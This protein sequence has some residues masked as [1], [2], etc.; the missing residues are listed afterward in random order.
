VLSIVIP[1]YRKP[2]L[3]QRTLGA[4]EPQVDEVTVGCEIVVVDDGS[5]DST[6]EV[7]E[8]MAGRLP[9]VVVRPPGNEGRAK[10]R[11]R[12]W[13]AATGTGVLFLDDDI[14]LAPGS[15]AAHAAA[16][17]REPAGYLGDVVT[18]AEVVDSTLFDYLDTRGVA[19][20]R[21]DAPAPAR[22]FLT[23]NASVPRA[24]LEAVGGFDERFGAYGFEDMEI[25]F[26]MEDGPGLGFFHLPAAR[27]QHI[28]HHTLEEY[29]EKKEIC[30]RETLPLLARLHPRRMAEM[31]LDVLPGM[32][33]EVGCE[34][35][36]L[37]WLL[38]LSFASGAPWAIRT[39]VRAWPGSLAPGARRR[40]YDYLVMSAYAK[41]LRQPVMS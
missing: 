8:T 14:V 4:L 7:L 18:A 9:L 2:D 17:E 34:N 3:L 27:G 13:R 23:Q 33:E 41:G 25:A 15:L 32:P 30:G 40:A 21:P 38:G 28:H 24:A 12:G 19:K 22:Y 37:R 35:P 26:R 10:A 16:Q 29:L 5:G 11:N 20:L 36:G 6:A 1:T 39:L 31:R